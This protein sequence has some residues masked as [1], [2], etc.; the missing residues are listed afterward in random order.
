MDSALSHLTTKRYLM[1]VNICVLAVHASLI[2]IFFRLRVRPMAYVN[3]A[4]VV[5]YCACFILVAKERVRWFVMITF[6]EILIHTFLAVHFVGDNAGFQVYYL[7]CMAIVLFTH[8]FA[9]HIGI[10]PING[11]I[12]SAVCCVLYIFTIVYSRNNT[13]IFPLDYNTQFSLRVFNTFLMFLFILT[14]FSLLAMVASRNELEL[15]RQAQH[16]NLTGLLNRRYLTQYMSNLQKSEDLSDYW[17]AIID[18]DN[19]KMFNDQYGH[20]CGDQVLCSVANIIRECCGKDR[21]VCR[22]GGEEFLVISKDDDSTVHSLLENIRA[23]VA[24]QEIVYNDIRHSVT[25]TIGAARFANGQPV[26]AWITKADDRLYDGKKA[27]KNR[28]VYEDL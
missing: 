11:P 1:M 6:V 23:S 24:D 25:V 16:D 21:T 27:G 22:W 10:K 14:F 18:I 13:A 9:V 19:F 26:D 8:Y 7:A 3:I 12:L 4:S 15:A 20:L 28:I 2:M 17:M 5:C